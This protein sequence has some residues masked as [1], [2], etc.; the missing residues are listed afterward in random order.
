MKKDKQ[1]ALLKRLIDLMLEESSIKTQHGREIKHLKALID[2]AD[3]LEKAEIEPKWLVEIFEGYEKTQKDNPLAYYEPTNRILSKLYGINLNKY[4]IEQELQKLEEKEETETPKPSD[5]ISS[6]INEAV[7]LTQ[8]KQILVYK[9]YV[10]VLKNRLQVQYDWKVSELGEPSNVFSRTLEQGRKLEERNK[11]FEIE[12][13]RLKNLSSKNNALIRIEQMIEEAIDKEEKC[14]TTRSKTDLKYEIHYRGML[15]PESKNSKIELLIKLK[16]ALL[17]EINALNAFIDYNYDEKRSEEKIENCQKQIKSLQ[18]K[19]HLS[20]LRDLTTKGR[21]ISA[22][23]KDMSF[24]SGLKNKSIES[25]KN[26]LS[27]ANESKEKRIKICEEITNLKIE[28][29]Q[30]STNPTA[31]KINQKIQSLEEKLYVLIEKDIDFLKEI[32]DLK[33]EYVAAIQQQEENPTGFDYATPIRES[34]KDL[35]AKK[36]YTSGQQYDIGYQIE[37]FERLAKQNQEIIQEKERINSTLDNI[38]GNPA[39]Q[40]QQEE[41]QEE[42]QM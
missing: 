7:N 31:K 15:F 8:E 19:S 10:Q 36:V 41:K 34:L 37:T 20:F 17:F 42:K 5:P 27:L 21:E 28:E 12:L 38:L 3:K 11:G 2:S 1:I 25:K 30:E 16:E 13:D 35:E 9:A 29:A 22:V 6:R 4:Q 32:L 18:K 39:E 23:K 14:D 26:Y 33:Y 24:Y 40:K